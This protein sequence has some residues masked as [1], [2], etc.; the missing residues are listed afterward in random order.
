[1]NRPAANLLLIVASLFA[2]PALAKS[3]DRNQ[4]MDVD[5]GYSDCMINE[6]GTCVLSGGVTIVQGTLNI[7]ATRADVRRVNGD[8]RSIKL[9][10][11]P[12]RMT[13]E[14]D[15]GGRMNATAS[16]IDYD[17]AQ[18]TIVFTGNA[19]VQQP[20]QGSMSGQRIVYNSRTGQVQGGGEGS[21]VRLQF[22]PR[23]RTNPPAGDGG[24]D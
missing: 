13:Q 2:A 6:S 19:T 15:S 8:P 14:L 16:Q 3:S 21:R 10:G 1:M 18:D 24:N 5:A 17:L 23:N 4:V 11:S 12:V 20:G 22:E 7:Q 9:T